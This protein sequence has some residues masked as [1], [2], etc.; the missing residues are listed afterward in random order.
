MSK[1]EYF[2]KGDPIEKYVKENNISA[3]EFC[4]R[5]HIGIT[6]YDKIICGKR[7]PLTTLFVLARNMGVSLYDFLR[8]KAD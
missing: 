2:V 7:V 4:K 8:E 5:F 1:L 6:T 3:Y